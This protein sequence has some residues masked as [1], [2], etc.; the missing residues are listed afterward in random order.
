MSDK[1]VI[2]VKH[3]ACYYFVCM[4]TRCIHV[5]LVTSLDL[6][7]F[8]LAF[9][10]FTNLSGAVDTIYSDKASTVCAASDQL[11]KLLSSRKFCNAMRKSNFSSRKIPPYA[12][13]Q[14]GS[15]ESMVK[16][17]KTALH[18]VLHNTRRMSSLIEL[19]TFFS[20]AVQIVNDRPLT[21]AIDLI[22]LLLFP[23]RPFW[24]KSWHRTRP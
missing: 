19:Q 3:G 12:S 21:S 8:L 10:K 2:K 20:D 14:G 7:S 11:T 4:C 15:W 22:T 13:S 24:G 16:L 17:S 23:P 9:S 5:E 1:T 6:N 18:R